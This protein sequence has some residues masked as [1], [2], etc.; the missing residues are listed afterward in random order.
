MADPSDN[1]PSAIPT[2]V[3]S[4]AG[5]PRPSIAIPA[6]I[7]SAVWGAISLAVMVF[8]PSTTDQFS[9]LDIFIGLLLASLPIGL[10]WIGAALLHL[11]HMTQDEARRTDAAL[12]TLRQAYAALPKQPHTD[13]TIALTRKL[14]EVVLSQQ[15]LENALAEIKS[16]QQNMQA[17]APQAA[18]PSQRIQPT[19]PNRKTSTETSQDQGNLGLEGPSTEVTGSLAH[20]DYIRALNFPENSEDAE[21]FAALQR[22]LKDRNSAQLVQSSQDILTLLSQDGIYMDD[23]RPDMARPEVWRR[24]A[25]GERG[26]TIAA[27]GGVRDRGALAR[28]TLRLK[29]DPIFRDSAHHFLRLFDKN[30]LT[31]EQTASDIE[32]SALSNTRTARAFMLLGR[33]AGTFD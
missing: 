30:F 29:Q 9:T 21:G 5:L 19:Q 1:S 26:R 14:D 33:V 4:H 17:P 2:F 6:A 15:M 20:H 25:A 24:F 16:V 23:L 11:L 7:L 8:G 18:P 27:L 32:I 22:V 28:A 10:I 31:F 12:I 3:P 13:G